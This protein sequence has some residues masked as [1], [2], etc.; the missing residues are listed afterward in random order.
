MAALAGLDDVFLALV[1]ANLRE[2]TDTLIGRVVSEQVATGKLSAP[3]ATAMFRSASRRMRT[4]SAS[5]N[6]SSPGRR[7]SRNRRRTRMACA[8]RSLLQCP[9]VPEFQSGVTP[10]LS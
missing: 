1:E 7:N 9:Q 5:T 10:S 8:A 3:D 2:P 6:C 4:C